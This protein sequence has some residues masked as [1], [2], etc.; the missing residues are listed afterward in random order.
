[1]YSDEVCDDDICEIIAN[2]PNNK[3]TRL[4]GL[5]SKLLNEIST[6]TIYTLTYGYCHLSKV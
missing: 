5:T 3:S 2:F 1:M 6:H 4:N